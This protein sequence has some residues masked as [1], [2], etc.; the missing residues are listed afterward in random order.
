MFSLCL[1]RWHIIGL[2]ALLTAPVA[3]Q[4]ALNPQFLAALG[5]SQSALP[6][7]GSSVV[8]ALV[9][10]TSWPVD[11][12]LTT[13]TRTGQN[14]VDNYQN[15]WAQTVASLAYECGVTQFTI[16]TVTVHTVDGDET[17][18]FPGGTLDEGEEFICGAVVKI[19]IYA[20]QDAQ[21][22]TVYE[23]STETVLD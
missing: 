6:S 10:Q 9:N 23:V 4:D 11:I 16:G 19:F 13:V 1:R 7:P 3:C 21:G 20:T 22:N 17:A 18:T 5:Q 15:L 2:L 12:S 14:L 8:I